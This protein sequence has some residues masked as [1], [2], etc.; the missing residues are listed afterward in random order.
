[1]RKEILPPKDSLYRPEMDD[2]TRRSRPKAIK[3]KQILFA[4]VCFS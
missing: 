3:E 2:L 4:E 1:M